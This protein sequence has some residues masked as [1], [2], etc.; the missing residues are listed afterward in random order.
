MARESISTF[1]MSAPEIGKAADV[2][3]RYRL[4]FGLGA[5]VAVVLFALAGAG[6]VALSRTIRTQADARIQDAARRSV[7]VVDRILADRQR[8]VELIASSPT[9]VDAAREGAARARQ[10]G[11]PTQ[12]ITTLEERYR[13]TRSLQ[14]DDRTLAYLADL[15]P[16]LDIAEVM[17]TDQYGFNAVTTSPSSDFV[18][19]DEDWWQIAWRM[20]ATPS[21]AN[22]DSATHQTVVELA[23]VVTAHDAAGGGAVGGGRETRVGVV[24]VK[25][26]LE[27][28]DSALMAATTGDGMRIDLVDSAGR[29][30]ASSGAAT[31][32]TRLPGFAALS[33][34]GMDSVVSYPARGGVQRAATATTNGGQWRLVAHMNENLA[35][36]SYHSARRALW[37]GLG[38]LLAG[39]LAGLVVIGGFISRRITGPA[40][41]LAS[42]AERVAAGDLTQQVANRGAEDEI[43]RLA[44]AVGAMISELRRL[45]SAMAEAARDTSSMSAEITAGSEQMA[46]SAGEIATTAS[47]LSQQSGTMAH[48]IHTL[49]TSADELVRLA[50]EL[51][52]GAHEGVERNAHLRSLALE[53][54]ARL[55]DSSRALEQ[56]E[57]DIG[58]GAA[59]IEQLAGASVEVRTFVALV[60]KLARQSKLLALNAAMEAA[61]AGEHGEGFAVV[62]SEVRRLASMSADA[63][64]RTQRVVGEV[65]DGIERSRA[66]S[67]RVAATMH[68]VRASTRQGSESF[69]EIEKAVVGAERWTAAVERAAT[70]ANSLVAELRARLDVLSS[71]T[72][73]FAAAMQEVAA[74]S[75]QQSASTQEI[76]AAAVALQTAAERLNRLLTNLRLENGEP[77]ERP[78][79]AAANEPVAGPPVMG[80]HATLPLP[81]RA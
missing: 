13:A 48:S 80:R 42:I 45:T 8:Q 60:Q 34:A 37:L 63:A 30:I 35:L 79:A 24:K 44:Q 41:E 68:E 67:E 22:D 2:S 27:A 20:G 3:L 23:H 62:A 66:S 14:V 11:L 18:Q 55:D 50:S 72:E 43:G 52:A 1:V 46:A 33:G 26:A 28:V 49:T 19:S 4:V 81:A 61:R 32:W 59:A 56:L 38:L 51:D 9:V 15:L 39:A 40:A 36:A 77:A 21:Y 73:A 54:R 25:F 10:L 70:V 57:M 78:G 53:N 12:P 29:V 16:K 47:D 31:R 17:L 71:G 5:F 64:E 74:S 69:G 6:N 76:A 75:E 7:L 65:L 58:T